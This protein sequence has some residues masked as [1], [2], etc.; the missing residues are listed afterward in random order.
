M[1]ICVKYWIF[2]YICLFFLYRF[3][4]CGVIFVLKYYRRS[5]FYSYLFSYIGEF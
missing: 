5:K 2:I 3:F 1:E 4:N